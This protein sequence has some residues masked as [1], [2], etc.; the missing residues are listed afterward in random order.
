MKSGAK[1]RELSVSNR[2][3]SSEGAAMKSFKAALMVL[4]MTGMLGSACAQQTGPSEKHSPPWMNESLPPRQ[5]A[6]LLVRQMTLDEKVLEIH[7]MNTRAHPREVPAIPRLGV[8]ALKITNGPAGA[9]PGDTPQH[10]PATALPS[11]LGL[12]A[13]W[14]PTL[15]RIFGH[16]AA[17]ESADRGEWV[18]EA[19]GLNITR[20]PQNG[21]NFEYFGEDPYLSA[22]MGVAEI[23]GIQQEGVMA[24]AKHYDANNQETDRKTI[25]EVIGKRTLR[26]IYMPAFEAGVK[27]GHTAAIMCAYPSVNG[28]FGCENIHQLKDVLRGEW[29]FQGFVQ[30]DYTATHST[31]P[32]ALAGL[33]LEMKHD[34]YYDSGMKAAVTEGKLK[35][36]V[37]DEM[38]IRRFSEMF[39]F[40]LFDHAPQTR[41]IPAKQDGAIARSIAE[42]CAVLLKNSKGLL[43]LRATTIHSV[44]IVGPYAG[45]AMTGGGGSSEVTPIYTVSPVEGIKNVA[46]PNVVVSYNDGSN[47]AAAAKAAASADMA[48][49]MVG[50]KDREGHDRPNL[51]L[52][53]NQ[54]QLVEAMAAANPRTVVILKT[55]GPVLMPWLS[56]VSAVLE[57][58]YP[59]EED[60][61]AVAALLFGKAN[62]SGKLPMTFPKTEDE[63]PAHTQQQYPGVN[64]AVVYSEGL[65]VGYR[66]YDARRLAPLF[67]FG[68]GL[69]YTTFRF[70]HIQV[71]GQIKPGEQV[72][73]ALDITN[74]GSRSGADV[75]Q[76]YVADPPSAGEP[77]RQL[78]GF[79]KVNLQPHQT[80]H[81]TI[82]L[83]RRA[84]SIWDTAEKKWTVTAGRYVILAGDSSRHLLLSSNVTVRSD[85][86]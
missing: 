10:E 61:N 75:V 8:P 42:Q 63:T 27:E 18:L 1:S 65:D 82:T 11:A 7:M 2:K 33:D 32:A 49:V 30:S 62:P 70:S 40:G 50:N 76:V 26:E 59:G 52:P 23:Q 56:K 13:S 83:D 20:V 28:L 34:E 24:E 46:G 81:V 16:V 78:R 74:T 60:G 64:G 31:V 41:P 14:D 86:K 39:R 68:Y 48:L 66:W 6:E 53:G 58:W 73:V 5:R 29:G 38:L 12:A 43:P 51:S 4:A 44:A 85:R 55:G 80:R 17:S 67:P 69:S 84:F 36:S 3:T 47:P 22:R 35:E 19:P 72:V 25:N 21:R 9:G 57:V 79:Q 45:A 71:P 15:A 54:N 37:L 77:P